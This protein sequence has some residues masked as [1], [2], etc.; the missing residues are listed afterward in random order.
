MDRTERFYKLEQWLSS[1]RSVP[2]AEMMAQL[3]ASRATI[4]RDLEYLR[5]RFQ[6]PIEWDRKGRG[7]R[8]AALAEG[9]ERVALPGLWF[10]AAEVQMLLTMEHLLSTLQPGLLGPHIESLRTRIRLLL[11]SG[12]HAAEAISQRIRIFHPTARAVT[13]GHFELLASGLLGRKRLRIQHHNRNRGDT[14]TREVSPQRLIL[15]RDNW[16][17][18]AWCHQ[19]QGLRSFALDAIRAVELCPETAEEL[20]DALLDEELASGYGIF[21]GSTTQTALLRFTPHRAQWVAGETWHAAQRGRFDEDGYYLL[22]V[23]YA[24]DTELVMDLMRYGADVEVLEP[25]GLRERIKRQL[26]Q[27]LSHY[28]D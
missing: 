18:D 1:G 20:P 25:T 5:D 2:L 26:R 13:P 28:A 24:Q 21:A 14:K 6:A 15:Y 4:Q 27:A 10:S 9:T 22:E 7:Y 3:G 16:Y 12:N 19:A 23:P 17:L 11:D 8:Y